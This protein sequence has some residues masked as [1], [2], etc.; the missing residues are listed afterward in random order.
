MMLYYAVVTCLT[1]TPGVDRLASATWAA[2]ETLFRYVAFSSYPIN[3]IIRS[4]ELWSL[5]SSSRLLYIISLE[6]N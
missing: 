5:G 3:M 2:V 4:F 6:I 1:L